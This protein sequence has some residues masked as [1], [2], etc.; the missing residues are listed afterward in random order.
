MYRL[1]FIHRIEFEIT[2]GMN[3]MEQI[4]RIWIEAQPTWKH[5][6][7]QAKKDVVVLLLEQKATFPTA[8]LVSATKLWN[9]CKKNDR[10][11]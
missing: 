10:W 3:F 4:R 2:L 11:Q 6:E 1:H 5:S 9:E 7:W 8:F